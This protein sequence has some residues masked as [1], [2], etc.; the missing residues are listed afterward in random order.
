[1][2]YISNNVV[3]TSRKG[4]NVSRKVEFKYLFYFNA[5][6]FIFGK[7]RLETS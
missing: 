3:K 7:H 6:F 1:M 4:L 2:F 5:Y